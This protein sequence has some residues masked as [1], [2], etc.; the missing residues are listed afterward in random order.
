MICG[1]RRCLS[2][3]S[4]L[5]RLRRQSSLGRLRRPSHAARTAATVAHANADAV[6]APARFARDSSSS[7]TSDGRAGGGGVNGGGGGVG[8]SSHVAGV[9]V[10]ATHSLAA[11]SVYPSSHVGEHDDRLGSVALQSP[12]SDAPAGSADASHDGSRS[13]AAAVK[14][15]AKHLAADATYPRTHVGSHDEP[16]ESVAVQ[17]PGSTALAGS[18]E[19]SHGSGSHVA[20]VRVPAR[21]DVTPFLVYPE[22]HVG[23]H[24][25]PLSSVAGQSP[26]SEAWAGSA[27]ASHGSG[28]HVATDVSVPA[29]H[30]VVPFTE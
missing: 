27:E 11:A 4:S 19:A 17:S 13:H 24:D 16:L 3:Q 5:G 20:D 25:E 21:Q 29:A 8:V 9:S 6:C 15:P 7:N 14:F 22:A 30:V 23:E 28:S 26:A 1:R 10:P 18:A 2:R 12:R